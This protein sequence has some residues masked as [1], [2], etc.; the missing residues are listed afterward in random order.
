MLA[1]HPTTTP[2]STVEVPAIMAS[3]LDGLYPL[4]FESKLI[5]PPLSCFLPDFGYNRGWK[6][7]T[8]MFEFH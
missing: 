3:H 5:L 8:E 2:T 1:T 7:H 6:I 4:N